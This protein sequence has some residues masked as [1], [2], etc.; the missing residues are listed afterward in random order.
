[1]N[2]DR[3]IP[4]RI[5]L[6]VAE[7][8]ICG[9]LLWP[10]AGFLYF[11]LRSTTYPPVRLNVETPQLGLNFAQRPLSPSEQRALRIDE[12]R[13]S[14]PALLNIPCAFLG[15]GRNALVPRAMLPEFWRSISWPLVGV[16]FWWI[17]GRGIEAL[18]ASRRH[19]SV[20]SITWAEVLMASLVI[21]FAS[22]L[23]VGF[24]VDP[25]IRDEFIYPWRWAI[26]ASVLW[27]LLGTATIAGR[28][29][30]WRIKQSIKKQ[31]NLTG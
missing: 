16:V 30:Q 20:P 13:I 12:L 4:F 2:N 25:S 1:M 9:V 29:M 14:V 6:P 3:A 26:A 17:A 7:L 27:I 8:L 15:L 5:V 11:Q 31:P 24:F 19:V 22:M 28:V 18:T 23:C 10:F 21:V